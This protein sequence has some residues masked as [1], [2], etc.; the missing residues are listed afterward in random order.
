MLNELLQTPLGVA[1]VG[2]LGLMVG[3][4][5]NVVIYRVPIM[6][7]NAEQAYAEAVVSG[8][9]PSE[10]E[11]IRFNLLYPPSRC[12]HCAYAI[13]FWQNI[14]IL[15]YLIQRGRCANCHAPISIRYLLVEVLTAV[16][17]VLVALQYPESYSLGFALLFTWTLIALAFIDAEHQLLPDVMTLPLMW[18]GILAALLGYFL[19][20]KSSVMGAMAGYLS[21]WTVY[22]AFK[23]ITGKEGMGY[24]DFKLLAAL[25]AWQ[26]A[27]M[28]PVILFFSAICGLIFGLLSRLKTGIPMAFGPFLAIAGWITFMYGGWVAALLG[29]S[30]GY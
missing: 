19:D 1:F 30:S 23:L 24:G 21:L 17:S 13:R 15:S 7:D 22:W 2:I 9:D 5:L 10:I 20:L 11:E 12:P 26:G 4:F 28:L 3:S 14:P 18:L 27:F 25:C 6:M 8:K 16:L 29:L